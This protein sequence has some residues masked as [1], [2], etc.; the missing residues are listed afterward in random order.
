[1]VRGY[2]DPLAKWAAESELRRMNAA[3]ESMKDL[4][5]TSRFKSKQVRGIDKGTESTSSVSVRTVVH[6][7]SETTTPNTVLSDLESTCGRTSMSWSC[8]T[9]D[10]PAKELPYEDYHSYKP[11]ASTDDDYK[12]FATPETPAP[13]LAFSP[14]R[15]ANP[16]RQKQLAMKQKRRA[17]CPQLAPITHPD[18]LREVH[19][20]PKVEAASPQ[21][22]D[23]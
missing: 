6:R 11:F 19:Q 8:S 3:V 23:S 5:S 7:K 9:I 18:D 15:K 20:V 21:W 10:E 14:N 4:H 17:R 2:M 16:D 12:P 13:K 22:W 1:M